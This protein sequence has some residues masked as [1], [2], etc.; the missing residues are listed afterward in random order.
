[1][2][3]YRYTAILCINEHLRMSFFL[4]LTTVYGVVNICHYIAIHVHERESIIVFLSIS[5]SRMICPNLGYI[6]QTAL[7]KKKE[8]YES[9]EGQSCEDGLPQKVNIPII[10]HRRNI[11]LQL[12]SLLLLRLLLAFEY[13]YFFHI[14]MH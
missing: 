13:S 2:C 10:L 6:S 14:I 8:R 4:L 3:L 12:N 5:H 11:M 7:E 9:P 1:M